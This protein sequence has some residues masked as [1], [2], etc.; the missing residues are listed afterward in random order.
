M[1]RTKTIVTYNSSELL[2]LR[3]RNLDQFQAITTACTLRLQ[4]AGRLDKTAA[5]DKRGLVLDLDNPGVSAIAM[6]MNNTVPAIC[7]MVSTKIEQVG[8]RFVVRATQPY[9]TEQVVAQNLKKYDVYH[10][11]RQ[12]CLRYV[13]LHQILYSLGDGGHVREVEWSVAGTSLLDRFR[14]RGTEL[15]RV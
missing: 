3:H 15:V 1:A 9:L 4:R 7:G 8:H 2:T 10:A 14:L 5:V 11:L 12:A 6:V 13:L